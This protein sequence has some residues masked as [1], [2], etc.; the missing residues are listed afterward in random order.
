MFD[1]PYFPA[2]TCGSEL[3]AGSFW[4]D[5]PGNVRA[6]GYFGSSFL[7]KPRTVRKLKSVSPPGTGRKMVIRAGTP[8]DLTVCKL[9]DSASKNTRGHQWRQTLAMIAATGNPYLLDS[10]F[11]TAAWGP[12]AV[13]A[14]YTFLNNTG[15]N[16]EFHKFQ[17]D[18][19]GDCF[20]YACWICLKDN[21]FR[22]RFMTLPR[23]EAKKQAKTGQS[24][25]RADVSAW[26]SLNRNVPYIVRSIATGE[27]DDT[28]QSV[29]FVCAL[30]MFDKLLVDYDTGKIRNKP[31]PCVNDQIEVYFGMFLKSCAGT[32]WG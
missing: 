4:R 21:A 5:M 13:Q 3:V 9:C 16:E 2:I 27:Q 20:Y 25:I 15:T 32:G 31:A 10:P 26:F 28:N 11:Q 30:A 8:F 19:D 29:G 22:D 18:A 23:E 12:P 14:T 7:A 6:H 24:Q 1:D 17:V